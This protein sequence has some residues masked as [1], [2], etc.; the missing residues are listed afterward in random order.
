MTVPRITERHER[1]IVRTYSKAELEAIVRKALYEELGNDRW[2]GEPD[3]S[4]RF[5]DETVGSPAYRVGTKATITVTVDLNTSS[6][7]T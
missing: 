7:T 4:I 6:S 2:V 5:E 1:T 3:V